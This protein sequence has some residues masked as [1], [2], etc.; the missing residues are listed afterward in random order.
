MLI[1]KISQKQYPLDKFTVLGSSL[2]TLLDNASNLTWHPYSKSQI[3]G[4]T[5]KYYTKLYIYFLNHRYRP[6]YLSLPWNIPR[7]KPPELTFRAH[8]SRI[9]IIKCWKFEIL[10]QVKRVSGKNYTR[11]NYTRLNYTEEITHG[12]NYTLCNYV[13]QK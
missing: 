12:W 11:W 9:R 8:V 4:K 2:S 3:E 1:L 10:F 6:S 13:I 5:T 7:E